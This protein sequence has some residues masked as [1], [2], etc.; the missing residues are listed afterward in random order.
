MA[1]YNHE[2]NVKNFIG[3]LQFVYINDSMCGMNDDQISASLAIQR[4]IKDQLSKLSEKVETDLDLN[5]FFLLTDLAC[6][7]PEYLKQSVNL[8]YILFGKLDKS[9]LIKKFLNRFLEMNQKI[10]M[11]PDLFS[12]LDIKVMVKNARL[13]QGL[14]DMHQ[15]LLQKYD[16]L[17]ICKL[18][19]LKNC[20]KC[21][22]IQAKIFYK[23]L[24]KRLI[25]INIRW[26]R[27]T[28]IQ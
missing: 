21:R 12:S 4:R 6:L 5:L 9:G 14:R 23:K 27:N 22:R 8:K 26:S 3:K 18:V 13:K 28:T 11:N 1:F 15:F 2:M 17:R 7:N 16:E 20:N 24:K 10:L 19:S 25:L